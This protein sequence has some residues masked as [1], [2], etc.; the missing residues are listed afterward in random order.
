MAYTGHA[1]KGASVIGAGSVL[2]IFDA[3]LEAASGVI[4][5]SPHRSATGTSQ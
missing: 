2:A 4:R 5:Q 1:W 3:A